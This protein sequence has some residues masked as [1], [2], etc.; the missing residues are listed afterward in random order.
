M[1]RQPKFAAVN[2]RCSG[3]RLSSSRPETS[4]TPLQPLRPAGAAGSRRGRRGVPRIP[5]PA[6][7]DPSNSPE[8]IGQLPPKLESFPQG[9]LLLGLGKNGPP[10]RWVSR[11]SLDISRIAGVA[12]AA[13]G[14]LAATAFGGSAPHR[15]TYGLCHTNKV[16]RFRSAQRCKSHAR[17]CTS[18]AVAHCGPKGLPR[19]DDLDAPAHDRD[20]HDRADH[21]DHDHHHAYHHHH[22]DHHHDANSDPELGG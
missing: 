10:R 5:R 17:F 9:Y 1:S 11:G 4:Q 8:A 22:A 16:C 2:D 20:D 14:F 15:W 7:E 21:D 13:A 18:R 12:M 6:F 19:D 3:R